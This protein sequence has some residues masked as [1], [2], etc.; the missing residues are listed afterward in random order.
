MPKYCT[1]EEQ[2]LVEISKKENEFIKMF[3]GFARPFSASRIGRWKQLAHGSERMTS[4]Q[5]ST[6][7]P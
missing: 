4:K 3:A 2:K 1:P 6:S 5:S 7:S